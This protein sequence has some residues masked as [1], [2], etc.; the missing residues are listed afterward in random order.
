MDLNLTK[1]NLKDSNSS[2]A[3]SPKTL[4]SSIIFEDGETLQ[5]KY[6]NGTL[7]ED[8]ILGGIHAVSPIVEIFENKE[9]VS[10]RLKIKD[11]NGYIITPNLVGPKGPKGDLANVENG[12]V[13]KTT[14]T[15]EHQFVEHDMQQIGPEEYLV[16]INRTTHKLGFGGKVVD[17]VRYI[18]DTEM[19]SVAYSYKRL[20]NGDIIVIFNEPFA[21]II[22][23]EGENE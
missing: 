2:T 10:Y 12:T 5:D 21:G 19:V 17:V 16:R 18:N 14:S 6:N 22:Y 11:I 23:L 8:G 4:A 3:L 15:Y 13:I 20:V 1:V 9:N 7:I